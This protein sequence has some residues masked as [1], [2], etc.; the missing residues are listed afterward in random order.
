MF[1]DLFSLKGVNW[2]T[3]LGGLGLNFIISVI[4]ALTG[5]F[6]SQHETY[7]ATYEAYGQPVVMLAIFLACGVAG[8]GIA[9]IA[10][11][12]PLKH[13]FLS[14]LGAAVPMLAA[15]F[16]GPSVIVLMMAVVAVAGNLNGA[17]LAAPRR[18]SYGGPEGG[19]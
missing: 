14:S 19:R 2:W 7:G 15:F 4:I 11:S 8:F 10:D 17:M 3:L 1:K 13:A 9:K 5:T 12:L 18:R 16:L 6:L